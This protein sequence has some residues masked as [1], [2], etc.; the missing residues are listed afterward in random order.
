MMNLEQEKLGRQLQELTLMKER[1]EKIDF[2]SS[3]GIV[4]MGSLIET[5]KGLFLLSVGLG[6]ISID[7]HDVLLLSKQSPLGGGLMGKSVGDKISINK[8]QYSIDE[9]L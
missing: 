1:F 3:S 5:N 7:G 8:I 9:I 2:G 4:K 6:K